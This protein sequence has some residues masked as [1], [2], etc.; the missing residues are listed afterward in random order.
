MY[1]R[2]TVILMLL[3]ICYHLFIF[4][5]DIEFLVNTENYVKDL[6]DR[7]Q[8]LNEN[9]KG[10]LIK[11]KVNT[12]NRFEYDFSVVDNCNDI[13]DNNSR[14]IREGDIVDGEP[15]NLD[16]CTKNSLQFGSCRKLGNFEC[17]DFISVKDCEKYKMNFFNLTC[18]DKPKY[19]VK[20]L[21][22]ELVQAN[23]KIII[24]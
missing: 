22:Y 15:F 16:N 19:E 21:P 13:Y 11:K 9:K 7:F 10:C 20:Y 5:K 4:N 12:N 24:N 6:S 3:F 23:T 2:I 17:V 8:Y 1:L 18:N 14:C